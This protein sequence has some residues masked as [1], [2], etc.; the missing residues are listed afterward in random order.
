MTQRLRA[1]ALGYLIVILLLSLYWLN[2]HPGSSLA[3][4]LDVTATPAAYL[5]LPAVHAAGSTTAPLTQAISLPV[6]AT[7]R[8]FSTGNSYSEALAGANLLVDGPGYPHTEAGQYHTHWDQYYVEKGFV[9]FD[10]SSLPDRAAVLTAMLVISDCRLVQADRP[11]QVE[12]HLAAGGAGLT[13]A[14]WNAYDAASLAGF[15]SAAC[16]DT[17]TKLALDPASIRTGRTTRF[18]LVTDRIRLGD[19]PPRNQGDTVQV[20]T[21]DGAVTLHLVTG[22][23]K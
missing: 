17:P 10:L 21:A 19:E 15:A 4:G 2:A 8:L 11:F 13:A 23:A 16:G 9:D 1:L 20:A 12:L 6:S 22:S 7:W 3:S 18:A 5:Y 14:D